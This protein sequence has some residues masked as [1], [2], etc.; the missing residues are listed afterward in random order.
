VVPVFPILLAT[1]VSQ[2]PSAAVQ[3]SGRELAKGRTVMLGT[4]FWD[5]ETN[6]QDRKAVVDLFWQQVRFGANGLPPHVQNLVPAP[7]AV[8]TLVVDVPF[9]EVSAQDLM[10]LKYGGDAVPNASLKPGTVLAVRTREGNFAKL[11]VI[12]YRDSHDFSFD[13]ARFIPAD[14]KTRLLARSKIVDRHLEV[15]WVLFQK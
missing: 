3:E 12:G 10:K 13:D 7:G 8:L 9:E 15:S 6:T 14:Q 4:Y 2:Q 11:K 1:L 5:I